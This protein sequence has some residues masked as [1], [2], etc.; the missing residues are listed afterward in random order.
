M[1]QISINNLTFGYENSATNVF[2]NVSFNFD[3]SWKLGLIGRNGKGKT[4]LLNIL[5]G[6][7]NYQGKIN[8]TLTFDYFPYNVIDK[9]RPT[10]DIIEEINPEYELWK[11]IIKL[12]ELQ[13][14]EDVIYQ[15][16]STL[17]NGEQ[18]KVMLAILFS[19]D[20]NFL[21]I[22]E[23]TNHLDVQSRQS[24]MEFLNKQTGFIVVSHDRDFLDGCIDHI[25]SINKN[26]IEIQKGNFSSYWLNKNNQDKYEQEQNAK[27]EKEISHLKESVERISLWANKVEKTIKGTRNSGVKQDKGYVSHKS[28]TMMQ[29]AKAIETRQ[30][31]AIDEK[32][33]LLKNIDTYD[34]LKI[35]P[36]H[37]INSRYVGLKNIV[38]NYNN[39]SINS[40]LTFEI[41][42]HDKIA[43]VGKNGCGKSSSSIL[44]LI[45]GMNIP[46]TGELYVNKKIKISYVS[47]ANEDFSGTLEQYIEYKKLDKTIFLTVLRKLDF[48]REMF[49]KSMSELSAGQLKK[50]RI[51][52]SLCT[53]ADLYIWDEPLNYIDVF[54]RIQLE[55]LIKSTD[56]TI[57]FV[58]HDSAF[59]HNVA[60]KVVNM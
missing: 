36:T 39:T 21:L 16:F 7:L 54:S 42:P 48:E 27:L 1:T 28:K 53:S 9:S 52:S 40:P 51:A 30:L 24:V 56:L 4:T 55:D 34:T 14:K 15:T 35:I 5:R 10:I 23:P 20:N 41:E 38:I 45:L 17:S 33:K 60:T 8:T 29:R 58:E 49:T 37:N 46:Y 6:K 32:E 3:S 43:L 25:M 26:N 31:K 2:D 19:K 57:I 47:Q 11:V 13:V 50:V 59:I 44:K 12:N 18:T 22:D